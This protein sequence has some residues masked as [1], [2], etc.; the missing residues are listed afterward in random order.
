[1]LVFGVCL[2]LINAI[3][4]IYL[5]LGII[6][7][8]TCIISGLFFICLY[9]LAN[10]KKRFKLT[11]F[12][13]ITA[14]F[15]IL[16]PLL[17][18]FNAGTLG[19]STAYIILLSSMAVI[20]CS[21]VG[22]MAAIASLILITSILMFIEYIHP[23]LIIGYESNLARFQDIFTA[24]VTVVFA[25]AL[26]FIMVLHEYKKEH[27]N[28]AK[29]RDEL[30]YLSYH[31]AL[32]GVHNRAYFETELKEGKYNNDEGVGI[33]VVDIDGLKFINDTLGHAIGD[34]LLVQA[35]QCLKNS[36]GDKGTICRIGGDEFAVLLHG[37]TISDVE[38][39]YK[40][41]RYNIQ[42]SNI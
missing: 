36:L 10:A 14:C 15:Y 12:L 32:T 30:L 38:N 34:Q 40:C 27:N 9:F 20:L 11:I 25:N 23:E 5:G 2:A 3:S 1:M 7:E 22:R 16:V 6:I 18:I 31:D 4:N 17:W 19:G 8:A 33:F 13:L 39:F 28:L 26:L 37:I 21:G 29:S 24:V 35:V 41:I 42:N